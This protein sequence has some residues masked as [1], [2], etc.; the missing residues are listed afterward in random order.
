MT[1]L[2]LIICGAVIVH[3]LYTTLLKCAE[4]VLCC[5]LAATSAG[6]VG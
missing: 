5:F 1:A 2:R 3:V 4:I 6:G